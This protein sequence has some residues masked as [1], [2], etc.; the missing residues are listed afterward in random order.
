MRRATIRWRVSAAAR[1]A[2]YSACIFGVT[3]CK[4]NAA[5]TNDVNPSS[6]ATREFVERPV[7]AADFIDSVGVQT[8]ISYVDTPYVQWSRAI[9]A[10][11]SLGV[12]HVRDG[13]ATTTPFYPQHQ[14][15]AAAGIR[16]TCG[17][18]AEPRYTAD[19]ILR[20]AE[21]SKDVEALEAPNE[22]DAGTNCGGGG[23]Q[24][25]AHA[26]AS[27]PALQQ[28]AQRLGVPLIG[29]SF[30]L[31][32]S[33]VR[34]GDLAGRIG[35]QNLHVYF[36]EHHPGTEGWGGGDPQ[37]HR[38]GSLAWWNDQGR[39]NA[40]DLPTVITETG[41]RTESSAASGTGTI[42]EE[43][44]ADYTPRTLLLAFQAG[45]R[46]TFLYE[47]LDEFPNTGYGLLRHDFSEKP[48]F[49]AV[50]T[51]LGLLQ[52][53][54][55]QTAT[56]PLRFSLATAERTPE[57]KHILMA[58]QDGRYVLLLWLEVSS[59]DEQ[60]RKQLQVAPK[61]VTLTLSDAQVLKGLQ[62]T[63]QGTAQA[64]SL[65]APQSTLLVPVTQHLTYLE[66]RPTPSSGR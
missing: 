53:T 10:L 39:L 9:Q 42:P 66:I 13:L 45:V 43:I 48:A 6:G 20:A 33:F 63:A 31:Q 35:V 57:L 49:T 60:T 7:S 26:V 56:T 61:A 40:G 37:N 11:R 5:G 32:S 17:I 24:G 65:G 34:S 8:H 58:K 52:G 1:T 50:K 28:A 27:L 38:Y 44:E 30:T 4:S 18:L 12:R 64:E 36:G 2:V 25:V 14:Q 51:L 22:C 19:F 15:L 21:L 46:R 23:E 62:F 29:P 47:L 55:E 16:C 41:Y 59:F 3:A 54:G